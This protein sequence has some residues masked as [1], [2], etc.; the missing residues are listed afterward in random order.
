MQ[1]LLDLTLTVSMYATVLCVCLCVCVCGVIFDSLLLCYN[2][3]H[4]KGFLF[5]SF[6]FVLYENYY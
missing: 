2:C 3:A 5:L 4:Q 1:V 6:T